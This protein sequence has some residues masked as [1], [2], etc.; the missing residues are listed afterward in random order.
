MLAK[1]APSVP[2]IIGP[3][4][5]AQ[6]LKLDRSTIRRLVNRGAIPVHSWTPGGHVRF[7]KSDIE[8]LRERLAERPKLPQSVKRLR[9]LGQAG[10]RLGR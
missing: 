9:Q 7:R 2:E 10:A 3:S 4:L 5:A 6:I 8:Q 1:L